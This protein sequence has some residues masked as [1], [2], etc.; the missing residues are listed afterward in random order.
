MG[1]SVTATTGSYVA[2]EQFDASA[3]RPVF[4]FGDGWHEQEHNPATGL[5]GV[6]E[7]ARRASS[8][9]PRGTSVVLR[10]E[11]ES[12]WNTSAGVLTRH[13]CRRSHRARGNAP[14]GL[15]IRYADSIGTFEHTGHI[16]DARS[17]SDLCPRSAATQDRRQL[18]LRIFKCQP[19]LVD[20]PA[21]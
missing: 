9:C 1:V 16:S 17:G 20:L 10:L 7:R 14:I 3:R 4:G 12:H 11:G 18:G 19:R 13:S 5:G 6:V 15:L 8:S 21:S 2:I